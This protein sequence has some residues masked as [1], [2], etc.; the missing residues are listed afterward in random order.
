MDLTSCLAK[1]R[2]ARTVLR[3][4]IVENIS[5]IQ[6]EF[7]LEIPQTIKNMSG[8]TFTD[9]ILSHSKQILSKRYKVIENYELIDLLAD[10][11]CCV[12]NV[13]IAECINSI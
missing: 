6:E 2:Q 13:S 5:S 12:N 9:F 8:E 10:F 4:Y 7:D 3:N 1:R 11:I